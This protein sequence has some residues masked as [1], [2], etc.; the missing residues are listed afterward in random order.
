MEV[1]GGGQ[2]LPQGRLQGP[3]VPQLRAVSICRICAP[4]THPPAHTS[5]YESPPPRPRRH[6]AGLQRQGQL[7]ESTWA[8]GERLRGGF[9]PLE[10][11]ARGTEGKPRPEEQGAVQE[12]QRVGSALVS[13]LMDMSSAPSGHP[14]GGR[15]G[16]WPSQLTG[17]LRLNIQA[18]TRKRCWDLS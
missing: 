2:G 12:P 3:Q 17:Q 9:R 14:P 8:E 5:A 10:S 13:A 16:Q 7:K 1:G 18:D 15:Q 4:L 6:N 11:R